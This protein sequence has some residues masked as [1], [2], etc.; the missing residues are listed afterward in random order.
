MLRAKKVADAKGRN[1]L[2]NIYLKKFKSIYE[3]DELKSLKF[4][5]CIGDKNFSN[6]ETL[7]IHE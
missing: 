2:E 7:S 6:D 5:Q 3:T 4:F 1:E